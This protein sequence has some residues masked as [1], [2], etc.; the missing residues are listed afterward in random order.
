MTLNRRTFLKLTSIFA[1]SALSGCS[2]SIPDIYT[3]DVPSIPDLNSLLQDYGDTSPKRID[4]ITNQNDVAT[5]LISSYLIEIRRM[6][7]YG[8]ESPRTL[9]INPASYKLYIIEDGGYATEYPI[10]IGKQGVDA[11]YSNLYVARKA[12]SPTWT[13]TPNMRAKNPNLPAQVAGGAPNNPLGSHAIYFYDAR[14]QSDTLLRAHGT[15]DSARRTVGSNESSGC[16]RM[17]NEHARHLH[18]R[19]HI[20][21]EDTDPANKARVRYIPYSQFTP[22][23]DY[24]SAQIM[25]PY[26]ITDGPKLVGIT[27]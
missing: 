7:Y 17:L 24:Q 23:M 15:M 18:A 21:G 10:G 27:P 19:V 20:Y 25:N 1:A 14:T 12:T 4:N 5:P 9:I 13:P 2:P 26:N 6:R 8:S 3:N 16:F 11:D 22:G